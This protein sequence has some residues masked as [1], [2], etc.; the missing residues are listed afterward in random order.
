MRRF[1]AAAL[2]VALAACGGDAPARTL[3]VFVWSD[4]LV[5]E[6]VAEFEAEAGCRV[7]TAHFQN[8][9]ELVA[10]LLAG[11]SGFDL[12]CPTDYVIPMLV[13]AGALEP[14]DKTKLPNLANLSPRFRDPPYD[15][16]LA[17]AVPYQWGVTGIAYRRSDVKDPPASWKDLFDE[18]RLAAWSGRISLLN[19]M[20]E[21]AAMALLAEGSSPNSRDPKEIDAAAAL[22]AKLKPHV[23]KFD[24][25]EYGASLAA[26]EIL[27]A[28]GWSGAVA[29]AQAEDADISFVIPSEG[30]LA[31]VDNWAIAKGAPSPD[32]AHAF[33]DFL[34][35]AD[36]AARAANARRYASVNEAA[37]AKIDPAILSGTAYAGSE[38]GAKLLWL[39]DAGEAGDLYKRLWSSLK[40]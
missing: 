37:R 20:R 7:Q 2:A 24:S 22:L 40:D 21:V 8:N 27:V 23:A 3:H 39:E 1:L 4:Y 19:D 14:L 35:R 12:V 25:D 32:L 6:L 17:H 13:K 36:V 33:M 18:A 30:T 29:N 5:P 38:P 11:N 34:L 31:Y 26:K 15:R 28:Q 9:D 10:K 16:G